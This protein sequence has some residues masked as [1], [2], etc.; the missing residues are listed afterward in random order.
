MYATPQ[1]GP[2]APRPQRPKVRQRVHLRMATAADGLTMGN[3]LHLSGFKFEGVDWSKVSPNWL[4]AEI[5]GLIVGCICV[6]PGQPFGWKEFLCV[7]GEL[8]HR[9]RAL[10][11]RA[12]HSQADA[13]LRLAG[14]QFDCGG[15]GD[16]MPGYQRVI[17]RRGARRV[18]RNVSIFAKGL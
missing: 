1:I 12:L 10:V 8:S 9:A 16:D 3:M 7:E 18:R 17:E 6:Y 14:S 5:G 2:T 4:V 11:V 15:V 13:L